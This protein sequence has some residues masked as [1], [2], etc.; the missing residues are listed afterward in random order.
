MRRALARIGDASGGFAPD[1]EHDEVESSDGELFFRVKGGSP[2]RSSQSK[3]QHR[4]K[5]KK[6]KTLAVPNLI[7]G[8][9]DDDHLRDIVRS[10]PLVLNITC[11]LNTLAT[12]LVLRLAG[13]KPGPAVGTSGV[14]CWVFHPR[15]KRRAAAA[16]AAVGI[17]AI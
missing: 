4:G 16:T 14:E 7:Q 5:K 17:V 12:F 13:W 10:T 8:W 1:G 9:T 15:G 2:P 3:Q 11:A 6:K